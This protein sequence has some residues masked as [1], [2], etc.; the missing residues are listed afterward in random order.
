[1]RFLDFAMKSDI[2]LFSRV[3]APDILRRDRHARAKQ[4][5]TKMAPALVAGPGSQ[6]GGGVP[7]R[8]FG[9]SCQCGTK[10]W[11]DTQRYACEDDFLIH[12]HRNFF[13]S[14]A[15]PSSTQPSHATCFLLWHSP[16]PS[17][18]MSHFCNFCAEIGR[19]GFGSRC[20]HSHPPHTDPLTNVKCHG[21]VAP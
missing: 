4:S 19:G 6:A 12:L 8:I 20:S 3:P 9:N 7:T 10:N 13:C 11:L 15:Q 16:F 5:Q 2:L 17:I 21:T 14:P 1:M 18:S